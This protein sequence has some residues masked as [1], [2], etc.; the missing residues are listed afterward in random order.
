[1]WVLI[2]LANTDHTTLMIPWGPTPPNLL[3]HQPVYSGFST[4]LPF[5][6]YAVDFPKIS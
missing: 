6:A 1:M 2:N 5:L 3:T 4:K